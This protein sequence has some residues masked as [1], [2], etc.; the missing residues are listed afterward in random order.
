MSKCI[1]KKLAAY[2]ESE[3]LSQQAFGEKLGV[4]Q[5]LVHQWLTMATKI[6]AERAVQ[7]ETVTDG[8][9]SR[10]DCRPDLFFQAA[11]S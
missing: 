8:K 6:T 3:E 5:G 10:Y 7:I 11:V 1:H 4:S 2:L 9:L